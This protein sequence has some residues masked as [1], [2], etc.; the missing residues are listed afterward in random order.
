[1][2]IFPNLIGEFFLKSWLSSKE[3]HTP[4]QRKM[5]DA[6]EAAQEASARRH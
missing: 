4:P 2:G 1:M 3:Q 5:L 6:F